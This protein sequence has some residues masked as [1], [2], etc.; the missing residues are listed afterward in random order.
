MASSFEEVERLVE[1]GE[2]PVTTVRELLSWFGAQRRGSWIVT[3]IRGRLKRAGILTAP[4]FESAWMDGQIRFIRD[5]NQRGVTEAS[6]AVGK[7]TLAERAQEIV[8]DEDRHPGSVVL[9]DPIPRLGNLEA[10]NRTP[11]TLN[12]DASVVEA[13]TTM[14]MHR[15][16]QLPVMSSARTVAGMV[17]WQSIGAARLAGKEAKTVGECLDPNVQVLDMSTPLHTAVKAIVEH[18]FV[19]VRGQDRTICGIVTTEDVGVKFIELSTPFLLIG[20]IENQVRTIIQGKFR[21][22]DLRGAVDP[23]DGGR[24]VTSVSDLSFGESVRFLEVPENWSRLGLQVDKRV[25]CDML[26][27][28]AGIR[29]DVMHFDPDGITPERLDTLQCTTHFLQGLGRHWR[30]GD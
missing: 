17:S 16:S 10:A 3:N 7:S 29:N 25:F 5:P 2:Q 24:Q 4:D 15:Y 18:E 23:A 19:L 22:E 27:E 14:M 1:A 8:E 21:V 9:G 6:S 13:M 30:R 28:V 20:E 12:R 11:V 26:R